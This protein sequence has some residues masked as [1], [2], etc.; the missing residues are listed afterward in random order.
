MRPKADPL[1]GRLR[2]ALRQVWLRSPERAAALRRDGYTC[3]KCH[4]KQSKAK[5]REFA[6]QVHHL[7]GIFDWAEVLDFIMASGLFCKKEYLITLCKKCHKEVQ[8]IVDAN[9]KLIKELKNAKD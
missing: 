2:A 7:E 9:E 5:G 4:S 1:R 6:V 8:K 3:Q